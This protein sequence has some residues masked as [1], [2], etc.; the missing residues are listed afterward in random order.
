MKITV[1]R[2]VEIEVSHIR[3][4]VPLHND[5][6]Q[7]MGESFPL[8][9]G[10]TWS[11]IVEIETGK[12]VEWPEALAGHFVV[13]DKVRDGGTYILL[14]PMDPRSP[15]SARTTCPTVWCPE[16]SATTSI[17]TSRTAWSQTGRSARTYPT[18]SPATTT[19]APPR[20]PPIPAQSPP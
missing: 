15:R 3:I 18:S 20:T 17:W 8:L 1:K 10:D 2:P 11:G 16:N 13:G 9:N 4:S 6:T 5:T 19:S 12:I 7:E 14:A